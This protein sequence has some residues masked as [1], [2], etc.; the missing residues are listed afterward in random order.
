MSTVSQPIV[1]IPRGCRIAGMP[2]GCLVAGMSRGCHADAARMS[3]GC[4]ADFA[5]ITDLVD[6]RC[7]ATA[8]VTYLA[9]AVCVLCRLKIS[10]AC[11]ILGSRKQYKYEI[12][13]SIRSLSFLTA[14]GKV[15]SGSSRRGRLRTLSS[16]SSWWHPHLSRNSGVQPLVAGSSLSSSCS[17]TRSSDPRDPIRIL[18]YVFAT[19]RFH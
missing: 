11:C 3:R 17:Y 16:T 13:R 19:T 8:S 10:C 6:V 1:S 12:H 14:T 7:L 2:R 15:E 18:A 4:S 9:R 5:P